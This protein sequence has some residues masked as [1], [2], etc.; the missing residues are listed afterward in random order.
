MEG[1]W[2]KTYW[3][4]HEQPCTQAQVGRWVGRQFKSRTTN[5]PPHP[6]TH[7]PT[8]LVHVDEKLLRVVRA[9]QDLSERLGGWLERRLSD[10]GAAAQI[11]RIVNA[12]QHALEWAQRT[13][14][15][16]QEVSSHSFISPSLSSHPLT[17]PST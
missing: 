13:A 17:H 9:I 4:R 3:W 6:P 14:A 2:A 11:V 7:P 8:P 1:D 15:E 16:L 12:H 5:Q 10:D